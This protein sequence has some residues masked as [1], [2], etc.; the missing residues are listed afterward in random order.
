MSTKA[1]PPALAAAPRPDASAVAVVRAALSSRAP[2][3]GH[4]PASS[5][6]PPRPRLIRTD[7]GAAGTSLYFELGA[8]RAAPALTCVA[9]PP[10]YN[11]D[12]EVDVI[13]YLHGHGGPSPIDRYWSARNARRGNRSPLREGLAASRND[14]V[15][16]APSLGPRSQAERLTAPGGL[17]EFLA[18]ALAGLRARARSGGAAPRMRHLIL[19]G[20]S[21]GGLV[22]LL[23]ASGGSRAATQALRQCWALD[24]FFNPKLDPRWIAWAQR[25][26]DKRL[27]GLVATAAPRAGA[28]RR[29]RPASR[30]ARPRQRT[31]VPGTHRRRPALGLADGALDAID[32]CREVPRAASATLALARLWHGRPRRRRASRPRE[33]GAA[34]ARDR[35]RRA[36]APRAASCP[37]HR[38]WPA[39][40]RGPRRRARARA[41]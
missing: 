34:A 8:T 7:V 13:L 2:A 1:S 36:A 19:A 35:S 40:P 10:G 37:A 23:L 11:V 5:A 25:H 12:E 27:I 9:L 15:L 28:R 17:D 30:R 20:H 16:V 6:S 26:P 39:P 33:R 32:R 41:G 18:H 24:A 3:A 4:A 29:A 14:A 31:A 21:G 38:R 22:M